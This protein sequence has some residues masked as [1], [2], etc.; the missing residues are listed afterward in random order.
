MIPMLFHL[1]I[2]CD[3]L[4]LSSI[5]DT[6]AYNSPTQLFLASA[7]DGESYWTC[8]LCTG[9]YRSCPGLV[10]VCTCSKPAQSC[11][12][13]APNALW[14]L[15]S[16]WSRLFCSGFDIPTGG[17][18]TLASFC[19]TLCAGLASHTR[20]DPGKSCIAPLKSWETAWRID[21]LILSSAQEPCNLGMLFCFTTIYSHTV[22][23]KDH[24]ISCIRRV[25]RRPYHTSCRWKRGQL[26]H[27][28]SCFVL[29]RAWC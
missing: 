15:L 2:L 27:K 19:T 11:N 10:D 6:L 23:R 21:S 20:R 1:A 18:K 17:S 14:A 9:V 24:R 22:Y 29:F 4:D 26:S 16:S 7:R 3:P 5:C 13:R 8:L 25:N 28:W 12:I